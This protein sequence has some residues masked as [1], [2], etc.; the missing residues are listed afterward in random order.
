M[1]FS[2]VIILI[3]AT[4]GLGWFYIWPAWGD[5]E[6]KM[7]DRAQYDEALAE[8]DRFQRLRDEYVN[9]FNSFSADNINRITTMLPEQTDTLQLLMNL[10]AV[11]G[12]HGV[13]ISGLSVEE[14]SDEPAEEESDATADLPFR[15]TVVSFGFEADYQT[16]IELLEDLESRLRLFDV[17]S[18]S[19]SS[20]G[21]QTGT[22]S[23]DLTLHTYSL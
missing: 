2:F 15:S 19:F 7:A 21:E 18:L 13:E 5:V 1:R 20:G 8:I 11:A 14:T 6:D 23:Y 16:M 9:Q 4:A 10:D 12:E 22:Y 17:T 3:I